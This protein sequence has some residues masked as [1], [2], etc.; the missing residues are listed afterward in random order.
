ME[1]ND[2]VNMTCPKPL[3]LNK[4]NPTREVYSNTGLLQQVRKVSNLQPNLTPIGAR[5][6]TASKA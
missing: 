6:G 4:G 3:E 5:N 2:N 1:T